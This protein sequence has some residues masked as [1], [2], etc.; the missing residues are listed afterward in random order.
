MSRDDATALGISLGVH[1]LLL[2]LF[3]TVVAESR[4]EIEPPEVRLVEVEWELDTTPVR[5]VLTGPPQQAAA[6]EQSQA[7]Q[8]PDPER[9]APPAASPVR[10][11]ER[12]RPNRP[13]DTPPITR[14]TPTP[15]VTPRRPSPPSNR[16]APQPD[17]TPPRQPQP[18]QSTG[19][20]GGT[21]TTDGN[22]ASGDGPGSGGDAA[23]EVG[24]NF[25]N[26]SV[27]SCNTPPYPG[28]DGTA[29]YNVTFAPSGAYVSARPVRRNAQLDGIVRQVLPS[30]RAQRLPSNAS[31][32]NQTTR[33]TFTFRGNRVIVG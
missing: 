7:R 9:P 2:L 6:G 12:P 27:I 19:T 17:P 32:V 3:V 11:P 1:A 14:N 15:E 30:C 16:T 10:T 20:G 23:A 8:Q 24:F 4:A 28:F 21:S 29:T 5:P 26:R 13:R 18:S 33:V 25:G 22:A 31:Q